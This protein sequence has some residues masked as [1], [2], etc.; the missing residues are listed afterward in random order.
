M[1]W[2]SCSATCGGGQRTRQRF[3][4]NSEGNDSCPGTAEKMEICN[5]FDCP[6]EVDP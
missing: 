4:M 2:S 6:G 5:S 3:C 1:S